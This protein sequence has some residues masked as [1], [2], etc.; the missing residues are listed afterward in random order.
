[1]ALEGSALSR[2]MQGRY[3]DAIPF[4]RRSL[5][6]WPDVPATRYNLACALCQ[7]GDLDGCERALRDV[8]TGARP[9]PA[10]LAATTSPPSH[11]REMAARDPDLAPLRAI[12]ERY[13][14][15]LAP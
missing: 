8:V 5:E 9:P 3:A 6:A 12:P 1:A 11:Y 2:M 4:L 13:A 15:A 14:R 7:S 10:F